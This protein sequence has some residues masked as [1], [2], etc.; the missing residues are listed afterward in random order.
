MK[1]KPVAQK[2]VACCK[3]TATTVYEG[4]PVCLNCK[5]ALDEGR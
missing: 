3:N 1:E 2:C 4:D 5:V